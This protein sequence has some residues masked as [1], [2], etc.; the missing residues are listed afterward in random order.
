MH[1]GAARAPKRKMKSFDEARKP[2][3]AMGSIDIGDAKACLHRLVD[4]A[5]RGEDV[6]LTRNGMPVARISRLVGQKRRIR[7]GLLKGRIRIAKGFDAV[8][9]DEEAL[10][11]CRRLRHCVLLANGSAR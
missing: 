3:G 9:A 2:G 6:V 1:A 7:F 4:I 11:A 8:M 10:R 5:A